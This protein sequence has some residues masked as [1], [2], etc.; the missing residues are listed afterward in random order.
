MFS[1]FTLATLIPLLDIIFGSQSPSLPSANSSIGFGQLKAWLTQGLS[2]LVDLRP[3]DLCNLWYRCCANHR[4]MYSKHLEIFGVPGH[5]QVRARVYA[6]LREKLYKG[7]NSSLP[8][9]HQI[10]SKRTN[11]IEGKQRSNGDRT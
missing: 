7:L 10:Q 11:F 5:D 3:T 8:T 1:L 4:I 9:L 2:T 6:N